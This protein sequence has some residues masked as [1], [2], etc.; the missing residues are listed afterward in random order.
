M[1]TVAITITSII[2]SIVVFANGNSV[3]TTEFDLTREFTT[4]TFQT[5]SQTSS[6]T[7]SIVGDKLVV[8]VDAFERQLSSI[9]SYSTQTWFPRYLLYKDAENMFRLTQGNKAI[10]EVTY[11]VTGMPNSNHGL[12]IGIGGYSQGSQ[13]TMYVRT[14]KKHTAEDLG[15]E[16][17]LS[18]S[19]VVDSN[20]TV[21]IAFS[22]GGQFE[23]SSIK[24]QELPSA[25]Q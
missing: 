18:S 21:K 17:T 20:N 6:T 3:I 23:I 14:S 12:Q 1:L 7:A 24:V 10:V 8:N 22:G 4:Y 2:N 13:S 19:F 5:T 25:E 16:F 11:K 15:K 9:T